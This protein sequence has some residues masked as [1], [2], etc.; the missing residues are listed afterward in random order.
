[1]ADFIKENVDALL[2]KTCPGI[3]ADVVVAIIPTPEDLRRWV[4]Y[5][6]KPVDLVGPVASVYNRYPGLRRTGPA[7]KKFI[8][9]L[10]LYPQRT[11][12][13]FKGAR[14]QLLGE[15]GTHTYTLRRHYV[16]GSHKFGRGSVLTEP[17]RH[18][19]WRQA[20]RE[21]AASRRAQQRAA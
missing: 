4:K 12:E 16:R 14:L 5:S 7:F 8:E 13:V 1:M 18:R 15:A 17:E 6:H 19:L 11:R 9:E 21:R 10:R 3:Y 20:H 2:A